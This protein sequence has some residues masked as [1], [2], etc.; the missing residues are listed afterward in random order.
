[1]QRRMKE[2]IFCLSLA[3]ENPHQA[4]DAF[5]SFAT[6][7][8]RKVIMHNP[9]LQ[10]VQSLCT[11]RYDAV[12]V[13]RYR[14][15]TGKCDAKNFDIGQSLICLSFPNNKTCCQIPPH[16]SPH[17][18]QF[19]QFS[20]VSLLQ[21]SLHRNSS[22]VHP[23]PPHQCNRITE[24]IMPL[25]TWPLCCFRHYWPWHLDHSSLILVWYPWLCSQLVQVISVISL[26]PLLRTSTTALLIIRLVVKWRTNSFIYNVIIQYTRC[27]VITAT[28]EKRKELKGAHGAAAAAAS[29]YITYAT[30]ASQR[31][32]SNAHEFHGDL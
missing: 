8:A 28:G 31:C 2:K 19:T 3:L 23:W 9:C 32:S 13:Q 14:Q 5:M 6:A 29:V 1:M 11:G 16:G 15:T 10:C 30:P 18:Q 27:K 12:Y 24:S 25:P 17:L 20:P 21:T 4:L 7:T 22:F 26:L